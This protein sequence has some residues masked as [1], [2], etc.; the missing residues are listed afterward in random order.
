VIACVSTVC[1]Y[2]IAGLNSNGGDVIYFIL[3]LFASLTVVESLMM[4]IAP[5]VPNFLMGIAAGAGLLGV[6]MIVCGFFQPLGSMPQPIFRYPLSYMSFHT[7]A[8]TGF[9]RSQFEG[10]GDVWGSP[11]GTGTVDGDYVLSYYEIMDINQWICFLILICMVV[12]YR[13][14]F[15]STLMLKEWMAR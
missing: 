5:I 12:F 13:L 11:D 10:T 2:F 3:D 14:L 7:Y 9:M 6:F 15:L 8:F 1:V 4:A